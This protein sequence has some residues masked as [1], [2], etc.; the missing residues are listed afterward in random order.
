MLRGLVRLI[1][2]MDGITGPADLRLIEQLLREADVTREELVIACK[3]DN[4]DYA[5]NLLAKSD[6]YQLL[7]ICWRSGQCSPIHDHAG[8]SCGVRVIDGTATET[9]FEKVGPGKVIPKG[10]ALYDK[11][12]VCVTSETDIHVISNDQPNTDLVTLHLYSPPL[13]MSYYTR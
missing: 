7:V 8:S 2:H 6:W 3:F 9:T 12:A 4:T 5:R 1:R 10:T 13:Q 11:D